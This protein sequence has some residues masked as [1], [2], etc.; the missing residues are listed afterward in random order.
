MS[1]T[2]VLAA[3]F[4]SALLASGA[5]LHGSWSASST[6]G[7][8]LAGRWTA[9][10]QQ[11]GGGATGTWTI[12]DD[13]GRILMQGG[14]SAS[15]SSKAWNGAWRATVAGQTGEY[16][17]VW[18]AQTALAAEAPLAHMLESALQA[19]VTGTWK[20]AGNSGSWSIRTFP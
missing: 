18:T 2:V 14:W 3:L 19:V 11:D 9:Q 10:A 5:D 13:A 20:A 12:Y 8:N 4:G 17:G 1:V 16:S 15:K 6:R 7:Q